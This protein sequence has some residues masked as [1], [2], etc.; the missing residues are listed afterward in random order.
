MHRIRILFHQYFKIQFHTDKTSKFKGCCL[1]Q[2][3]ALVSP[4]SRLW[5]RE[6]ERTH[7]CVCVSVCTC[8]HMRISYS[9]EMNIDLHMKSWNQRSD[10]LTRQDV[11]SLR[12]TFL[13]LFLSH[14][15][16][17]HIPYCWIL[18]VDSL[19]LYLSLFDFSIPLHLSPQLSA[20]KDTTHIRTVGRQ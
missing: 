6:E 11:H 12:V 17:T 14:D 5:L 2:D 3:T 15:L 20:V 8:L 9:D 10:R 1:G 13:F 4:S 18:Q 7:W 16:H 19:C